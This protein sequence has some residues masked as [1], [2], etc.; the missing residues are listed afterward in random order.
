M[1]VTPLASSSA[2]GRHVVDVQRGVGVLLRRELHPVAGRLPD[3]EARVADPD[4]EAGVIVGPQ[5][6]CVE[7]ER[8]RALG[9]LR[10]DPHEVQLADHR[11]LL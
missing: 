9:V 10:R 2:R 4:V 3:A 11:F 5:P 8:A 6:E 1:K 7:I